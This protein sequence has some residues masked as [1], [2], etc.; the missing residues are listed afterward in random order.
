MHDIQKYRQVQL[1][2]ELKANIGMEKQ[3][4]TFLWVEC[5]SV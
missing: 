2:C 5:P 3:V 1:A 4:A